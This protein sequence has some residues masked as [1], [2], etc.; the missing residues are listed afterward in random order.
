MSTTINVSNDVKRIFDKTETISAIKTL[1]YNDTGKVFFL[2]AS[3]GVAVTLP[4]VRAGVSFKFIV[5]AA[6]SST[7]W[8]I[9]GG[10]SKIQGTVVVNGA[11]ILGENETTIT[12]ANGAEKVGDFVELHCDG[13]NWLLFGMGSAGSS[14]TLA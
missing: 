9:T 12:F 5:A 10:A 2:N 13:T 14:I 8:T 6:F 3:G 11:S 7:D 1:K 4:A